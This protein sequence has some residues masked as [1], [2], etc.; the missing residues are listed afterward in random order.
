MDGDVRDLSA[1]EWDNPCYLPVRREDSR[2][3][4]KT[5]VSWGNASS[6][7][8]LHSSRDTV[9]ASRFGHLKGS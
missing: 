1:W 9:I 7:K 3:M 4:L 6:S 5:M 2:G 8:P